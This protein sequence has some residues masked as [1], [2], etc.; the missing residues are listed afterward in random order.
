MYGITDMIV[1]IADMIETMIAG[2]IAD[3]AKET[4]VVDTDKS[5]KADKYSIYQ[6]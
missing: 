6:I 1:V 3:T 2:V 4:S 5:Q